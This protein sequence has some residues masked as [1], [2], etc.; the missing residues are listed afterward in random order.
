MIRNLRLHFN[1]LI[2]TVS[3]HT[4]NMTDTHTPCPCPI[5]FEELGEKK[6]CCNGMGHKFHFKCGKM[7]F[8]R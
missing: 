5:C 1:K 6:Y 8:N 3:N 4:P 2:D 7:E